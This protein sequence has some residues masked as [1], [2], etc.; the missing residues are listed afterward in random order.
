MIEGIFLASAS[1]G[2]TIG[3]LISQWQQLGFF[4]YVFP[5]LL[6]FALV[7]AILS[8]SKVFEGNNGVNAVIAVVVGLIAIQSTFVAQFFSEIIPRVGVGLSIILAVILLV[9]LF[10]TPETWSSYV[11][12]GIGAIVFLVVVFKSADAVGWTF[13]SL[14]WDQNWP[15]IV[16]IAFILIV[17]GMAVAPKKDKPAKLNKFLQS[18][19]DTK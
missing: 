4:A 16:G 3:N 12:F 14:W 11:L 15:L 7:Y 5:F 13:G 1:Y 18:V 8:K 2:G 10:F 19:F 6:I 17:V 9:G